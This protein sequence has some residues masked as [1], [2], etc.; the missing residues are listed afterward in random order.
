M[1]VIYT[2]CKICVMCLPAGKVELE[3]L[4]LGGS[5]ETFLLGMR[6]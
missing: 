6:N 2:V 1:Q 3:I 4:Q 5:L